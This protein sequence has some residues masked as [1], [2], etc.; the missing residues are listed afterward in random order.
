MR[1]HSKLGNTWNQ[2]I[3]DTGIV[4]LVSTLLIF[5]LHIKRTHYMK[6]LTTNM[7]M[8]VVFFYSITFDVKIGKNH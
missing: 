8:M 3:R 1:C 7:Q 5:N 6:Y 2:A 4:G